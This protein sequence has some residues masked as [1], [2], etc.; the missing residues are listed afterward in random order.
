MIYGFLLLVWLYGLGELTAY[1]VPVIPLSGS[2]WGML[3]LFVGLSTGLIREQWV[4]VA[5]KRLIRGLSL[6]FVPAGVAILAFEQQLAAHWAAVLLTIVGSLV[7]SLVIMGRFGQWRSPSYLRLGFILFFTN[8]P[9]DSRTRSSTRQ[10][11][12]C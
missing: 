2:L 6:F 12:V 7:V 8:L 5:A 3:Y 1:L 11:G 4:E 9:V 10:R